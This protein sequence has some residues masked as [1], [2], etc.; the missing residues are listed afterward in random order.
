MFL[1]LVLTFLAFGMG[2]SNARGTAREN[3]DLL[4]IRVVRAFRGGANYQILLFRSQTRMRAV[5]TYSVEE[6]G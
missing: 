4:S 5:T 3:R 1:Y 6:I 2:L